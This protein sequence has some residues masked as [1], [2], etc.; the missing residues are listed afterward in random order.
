MYYLTIVGP[1]I[2]RLLAKRPIYRGT[3]S[4][5]WIVYLYVIVF[6]DKYSMSFTRSTRSHSRRP[7]RSTCAYVLF[8]VL[9]NRI[10]SFSGNS[11]TSPTLGI[12]YVDGTRDTSFVSIIFISLN[13]NRCYY[14][15]TSPLQGGAISSHIPL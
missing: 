5:F 2:S 13:V 8:R 7:L 10:S 12:P 9:A 3:W 14:H 4:Y 6:P 15:D 11:R 1:I